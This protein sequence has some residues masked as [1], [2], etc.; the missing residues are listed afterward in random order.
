MA[1]KSDKDDLELRTAD[2]DRVKG[3]L[4]PIE[5]GESWTGFVRRVTRKKKKA[6]KRATPGGG[7]PV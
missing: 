3:G 4:L 2:A 1:A 7:R 5:P 6:A